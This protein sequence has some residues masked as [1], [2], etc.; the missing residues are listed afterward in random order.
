MSRR[1]P[2][3]GRTS[4]IQHPGIPH[5]RD[6]G[7]MRVAVHDGVTARKRRYQ[8]LATPERGPRH[9]NH[10]DSNTLD[11]DDPAL[12]QG[13][14]QR[15][16]VHVSDHSLDRSDLPEL[17]EDRERDEVARVQDQVRRLQPPQTL[18][19]QS[20]RTPRH[21]RVGDDCDGAQPAAPFRNAPSR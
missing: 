9:V 6:L 11:L 1:S 13:L 15:G 20:P 12:G 3:L 16:F 14:S 8:S 17:L 2:A 19:R 10:P 5:A 21:M 18:R 4:G 7:Q